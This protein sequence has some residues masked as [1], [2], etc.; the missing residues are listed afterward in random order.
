MEQHKLVHTQEDLKKIETLLNNVDVIEACINKRGN[1]KWEF[2]KLTN[3]TFFDALVK[4]FSSTR[5]TFQL[6]VEELRQKN[7]KYSIPTTRQTNGDAKLLQRLLHL[8]LGHFKNY[9]TG[10]DTA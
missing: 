4:K 5:C 8:R 10:S 9:L 6:K 3:V 7:M 1:T 2:N